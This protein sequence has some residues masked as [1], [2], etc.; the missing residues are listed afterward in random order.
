VGISHTNL[1][2]TII[3][4]AWVIARNYH[5]KKTDGAGTKDLESAADTNTNQPQSDQDQHRLTLLRFFLQL[6]RIHVPTIDAATANAT[7]I[8]NFLMKK[9][10]ILLFSS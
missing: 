1:G 2:E 4:S 10:E 5:V 3:S 8:A 7:T 6:I 9:K